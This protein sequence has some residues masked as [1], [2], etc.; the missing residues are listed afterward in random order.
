MPNKVLYDKYRERS[1]KESLAYYYRNRDK[2]LAKKKER[3]SK[4]YNRERNLMNNFG[5]TTED[6]EKL[7]NE[8]KGLCAICGCPPWPNKPL[9]VDHNHKTGEVRALLCHHC[10]I[11]L[12]MFKDDI[13]KL[14]HAIDYLNKHQRN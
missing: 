3:C 5:I 1:R 8:Q 12:G 2:V 11:G 6:Y 14:K 7:Y 9:H 13:S 10:N 4:E